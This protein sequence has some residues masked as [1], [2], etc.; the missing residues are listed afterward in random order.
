VL[1][2][3][4]GSVMVWE[5]AEN[6]TSLEP[7]TKFYT[8]DL[9]ERRAAAC[10]AMELCE[11]KKPKKKKAKGEKKKKKGEKGDYKKTKGKAEL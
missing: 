11:K 2:E 8:P 10:A 6:A 1:N 4:V 5:R 9:G 3:R 7:Q